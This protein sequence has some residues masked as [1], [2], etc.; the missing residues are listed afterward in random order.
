VN[1]LAFIRQ[2][3]DSEQLVSKQGGFFSKL[4]DVGR[5]VQCGDI[6]SPIAFNIVVD[7]IIR[8][9]EVME[10]YE[11]EQQMVELPNMKELLE[12]FYAD[13]GVVGD[14]DPVKVQALADAFTVWFKQLGLHMNE[15]KTKAMVV[16][17]VR[18][19]TMQSTEAFNHLHTGEGK[20][21]RER[22]LEKVQCRLCGVMI[23]RKHMKRHQSHKVCLSK[24]EKWL[25]SEE[26][27]ANQAQQPPEQKNQ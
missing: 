4:F 16:K 18:V 11:V 22:D 19:T 25:I 1:I 5:G 2:V 12:L 24:R 15:K 9:I 27:P 7:A 8:D 20:T 21:Q 6:F 14:E 13:D 17:G 3:W 10:Q 23:A 26:N